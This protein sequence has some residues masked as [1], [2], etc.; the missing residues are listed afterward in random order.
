MLIA[1]RP[2]LARKAWK[3]SEPLWEKPIQDQDLSFST[4]RISL[5]AEDELQAK[6]GHPSL[7][8]ASALPLVD[9]EISKG[10]VRVVGILQNRCR[11]GESEYN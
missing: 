1:E 10:E 9:P 3:T 2:G 7:S 5:V 4:R 11:Q 8:K 6:E